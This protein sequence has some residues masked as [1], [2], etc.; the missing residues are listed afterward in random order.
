MWNISHREGL[1]EKKSV[2]SKLENT[3]PLL[4]LTTFCSLFADY[5]KPYKLTAA[6]ICVLS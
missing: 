2:Y 1:P 6:Q 5:T 4:L 3:W